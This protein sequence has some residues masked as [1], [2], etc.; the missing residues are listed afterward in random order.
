M[1]GDFS[2]YGLTAESFDWYKFTNVKNFVFSRNVPQSNESTFT[3]GGDYVYI[4]RLDPDL[5]TGNFEH[6]YSFEFR[7][8]FIPVYRDFSLYIS[9]DLAFASYSIG[10][11][12]FLGVRNDNE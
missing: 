7:D 2:D 5:L 6:D 3:V 11:D 8:A 4:T 10:N 1:K 9:H 12:L